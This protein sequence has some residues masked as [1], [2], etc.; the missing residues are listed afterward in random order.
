MSQIDSKVKNV[1]SQNI[2]YMEFDLKY[3]DQLIEFYPQNLPRTHTPQGYDYLIEPIK[4]Q[5]IL[6]VGL[7]LAIIFGIQYAI[8]FSFLNIGYI[9]SI[10]IGTIHLYCFF[11]AK[12]LFLSTQISYSSFI[13]RRYFQ[14]D[15]MMQYFSGDRKFFIAVD[16]EK[17][18]LV[19]MTTY[20]TDFENV[21]N[22]P[23]NET[24]EV[25]RVA[26]RKEYEGRGIASQIMKMVEEHAKKINRKYLFL[27]KL[28]SNKHG[29]KFYQKQGFKLS[30]ISEQ[31]PF[32]FAILGVQVIL[33]QKV[34][35]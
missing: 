3:Y 35:Q 29:N 6:I 12:K 15:S 18:L 5:G 16:T 32:I 13:I 22:L 17:D 27:G 25:S 21:L 31:R 26:V 4:Q 24:G 11:I 7:V 20:D 30:K 9:I 10:F 8:L 33:M 19:A 1:A 23:V 14:K 28:S 2:K 34:I